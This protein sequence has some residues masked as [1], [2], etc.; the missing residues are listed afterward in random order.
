MKVASV[1]SWSGWRKTAVACV[2]ALVALGT[3]CAGDGDS[4][5]LSDA[6]AGGWSN[7]SAHLFA[8]I[9]PDSR[10]WLGD[11]TTELD[12]PNPCTVDDTGTGFHCAQADEEDS[13]FDGSIDVSGNQL[14]LDIV[15]CPGEPAEC[16]LTYV[17]DASLTCD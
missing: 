10:M 5:S 13:A 2:A 3:A 12:G 14:T 17:R 4:G 7:E 16:H 6:I 1:G 9:A 15:P 11:S 8:C